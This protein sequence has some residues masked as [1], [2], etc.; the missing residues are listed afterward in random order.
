MI[1]DVSCR[2]RVL[3]ALLGLCA[4]DKNGGPLRMS[5]ILAETLSKETKFDEK[6]LFDGLFRWFQNE[7]EEE[8][9][10]SG[11]TFMRVMNTFKKTGNRQL[12]AESG[13]QSAGPNAAHRVAPIACCRWIEDESV[14]EFAAR[15]AKTTHIH[16]Q[17]G[18]RVW[19]GVF[20]VF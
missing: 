20:F 2:S 11:P 1:S 9:F 10:D 8:C 6:S 4:G 7:D 5:L 12:A 16:V 19:N 15:Q 13:K 14:A 17:A 18:E 3:G